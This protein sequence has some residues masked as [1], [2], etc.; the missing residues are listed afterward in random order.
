MVDG[1]SRVRIQGPIQEAIDELVSSGKEIG[2]QVAVIRDGR[3]VVDAVSGVAD[4][5]TGA[6]VVG[7]TLFYAASTAKGVATSLVHVL[8]ERSVLD[9]DMRVIDAWPEFGSHGKEQVRLRHVLLHTA[10]VPGVPSDTTVA[11]LCDWDHM[12]AVIAEEEPWWEAGTRFGYHAQTFGFLV[13][14]IM[15]RATGRDISTLLREEL[16]GPLGIEADVHFAIPR[17][18]LPRVARQVAS[19]GPAPDGPKPGSPLD[20]AIP[21]GIRPDA[22]VANRSDVLTS[23]IPSAGTMTA[24]GAARMY[25]AL[26]GHVAGAPLVSPQRLTSMAAIAF[27]GMDEV[28]GFPVS[29]GFGYSP[30]R[31]SKIASRPG[32]TFGMM[33]ANG[34]AAYAD[35]DSGVVVAVMR[36]R[37]TADLS[38]AAK[39]DQIVAEA[40]A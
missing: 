1:V 3:L 36:N 5:R 28:M 17:P 19:D 34:S 4:P 22:D 12:C 23:N 10:G 25:S 15:R 37:F 29:W 7:D 39:I 26:L 24:R 11:D 33:G 18:L 9:Y 38:T 35:I 40:F 13:G 32:S 8:V 2:L 20:R 27:T 14:E 16:T 31:P 30:D 6:G 21:R